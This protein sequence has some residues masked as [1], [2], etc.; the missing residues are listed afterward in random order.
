MIQTVC[1]TSKYEV[2]EVDKLALEETLSTTQFCCMHYCCIPCTRTVGF[3]PLCGQRS[4]SRTKYSRLYVEVTS[5]FVRK[6]SAEACIRSP[7][8]SLFTLSFFSST[9][10]FRPGALKCI[11]ILKKKRTGT[12]ASIVTSRRPQLQAGT[13]IVTY[14]RRLLLLV[15]RGTIV[16]LEHRQ[17]DNRCLSPRRS[18]A[19]GQ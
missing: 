17:N 19:A 13:F 15:S 4:F 16:P 10:P 18:L 14:A 3:G 2:S 12:R 6:T 11:H 5:Y 8:H 9:V 7:R 1:Y